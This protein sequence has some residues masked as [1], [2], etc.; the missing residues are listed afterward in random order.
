MPTAIEALLRKGVAEGGLKHDLLA[1]SSDEGVLLGVEG[2]VA[3]NGV[4]GHH[5]R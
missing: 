3:G 5:F 4:G 1:V 2:E